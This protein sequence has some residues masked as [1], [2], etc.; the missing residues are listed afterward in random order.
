M[1]KTYLFHTH[2]LDLT[3]GSKS[4]LNIAKGLDSEGYNVNI[5]LEKEIVRYKVPDNINLYVITL[6]GIKKLKYNNFENS[7]LSNTY[8]SKKHYFKSRVLNIRPIR[9]LLIWLRYLFN[10]MQFPIKNYHMKIFLQNKNID[11]VVSSNMYSYLEHIFYYKN[12]V[13]KVFMSLRNSPV[14][15]YQN[16]I[17][18]HILPLRYYYKKVTCIGVSEESTIEMKRFV[19]QVN[20]KL[21]TIYN[22]FDFETIIK[23]SK[24][25]IDF[26]KDSFFISVGGL[27]QRKRVDLTIRAYSKIKNKRVKLL[28]V[29]Q[30]DKEKDLKLLVRELS[31]CERVVFIGAM[32]NPYKY[33]SKAK[34]LIMT[35]ESE[36]LP[37]V[38]IESLICDTPTISVDC[39]TGPK[40]ILIDELKELL[41]PLSNSDEKIVEGVREKM[42]LVLEKNIDINRR[43]LERFTYKK[44]IKKWELI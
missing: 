21:A 34:A 14:N 41:V 5:I 8:L 1:K 37:R 44:V 29:G 17:T 6:K 39:P 38:L 2:I 10:L 36:G 19:D 3:G 43:N 25:K 7:N 40:E 11:R 16:R 15:V 27:N 30:G 42:E 4:I 20:T 13:E 24:E 32:D 22:P 31:M 33:M 9:F 18:L 26:E 23:K 12:R 28:L 35:S